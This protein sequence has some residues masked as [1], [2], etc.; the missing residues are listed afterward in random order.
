[1]GWRWRW[2]WELGLS[3]DLS[4]HGYVIQNVRF[5]RIQTI[6]VNNWMIWYV[7]QRIK[8]LWEIYPRAAPISARRGKSTAARASFG[9]IQPPAIIRIIAEKVTWCREDER[10]KRQCVS[11]SESEHMT[12]FIIWAQPHLSVC[13]FAQ[14]L[15]TDC[16]FSLTHSI[17]CW[18]THS[19]YS[20]ALLWK[21][22]SPQRSALRA[23]RKTPLPH[24]S[25]TTTPTMT[26]RKGKSN[27]CI[28]EHS[29]YS[30][31][32]PF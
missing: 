7:T 27:R 1:M 32:S 13:L 20:P 6:E 25:P 15:R 11:M 31:N 28:H 12:F 4:L 21:E 14:L 19:A 18:F 9:A 22:N 2:R 26:S 10:G 16:M 8:R 5:E 29:N 23:L 3:K 17:V 30:Q 24:H